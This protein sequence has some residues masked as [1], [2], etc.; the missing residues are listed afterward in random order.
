M[1]GPQVSV[2]MAVHN[3][4]SGLRESVESVLRQDVDL[5]LVVVND[6]STDATALL[7]AERASWDPRLRV[8]HR[9]HRGL[10]QSLIEACSLCRGDYVA[11]QD[12]SDISLPGRL[13]RQKEAL[14]ADPE[15]VM[16]SCG[17]RFVGPAGEHLY[18]VV[19][20]EG[21][22][23]RLRT[24]DANALRGPSHHGSTMWRRAVY[25]AVGGYRIQFYLAQDLDLWVRLAERGRHRVLPEI[26]YQARVSADSL[27]GRYRGEQVRS[28]R[29]IVEAARLRRSGESEHPVLDEVSRIRPGTA[30]RSRLLR[31]SA[32]MYFIGACLRERGDRRASGYFRQALAANPLHWKSW[33]RLLF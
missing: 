30:P 22:T 9:P 13:K 17:T 23:E 10:T 1:V 20:L 33:V 19:C 31:R 3:D 8:L 4:A 24:L 25:E 28:R 18:D 2:V 15:V 5:E 16:V 26:G 27:T 7:L 21:A 29:L 32:A 6:G 12:S 14:D 11:R